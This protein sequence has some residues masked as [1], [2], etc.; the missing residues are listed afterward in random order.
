M[1]PQAIDL[2]A[3]LFFL[4]ALMLVA[5]FRPQL[6]AR[7]KGS[8]RAI[9]GGLVTLTVMFLSNVY[10]KI[11]VFAAVPFL[12]EPLFYQ[13]IF[14]IGVITGLTFLV[15]GV[16]DW[17]RL[18]RSSRK[19]GSAQSDQLEFIRK[20][21]QL[22]GVEG[23]LPVILNQTLQYMVEHF[24]FLHGAVYIYSQKQRKTLLVA[25]VGSGEFAP[26]D[27]ENMVFESGFE[28]RLADKELPFDTTVIKQ[29][30]KSL[31][32]PNLLVPVVVTGKLAAFF[33]LWRQPTLLADDYDDSL[34]KL[35]ADIIARRIELDKLRLGDARRSLQQVWLQN[36]ADA[37]D[38]NADIKDK[39]PR[40]VKLF[41]EKIAADL[42][43]I[44][45]IPD[46]K[47]LQRFTV[48]GDSALLAERGLDLSSDR[49]LDF[50]QGRTRP[51][52][53]SDIQEKTVASVDVMFLNAGMRSMLAVSLSFGGT[54]VGTLVLASRQANRYTVQDADWMEKAAPILGRMAEQVI[55]QERLRK[56]ENRLQH[57][58]N[59]LAGCAVNN[60]LA[61]LFDQACQLLSKELRTT[62]VRISTY[63]NGR[64]FLRSRALATLRQIE[65]ITPADGSMILSLMPHHE[66]VRDTGRL[67]MINPQTGITIDEAEARMLGTGDL[68]SALLVPL[69]IEDEVVGVI[70]IA[71]QRKGERHTYTETDVVFATSVATALSL[72]IQRN[73]RR[74][75]KTGRNRLFDSPQSRAELRSRIKSSLSGIMGSVEMLKSRRS[76]ID[77]D[78]EKYLAIIDRS[79]QKINEYFVD[80]VPV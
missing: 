32:H 26:E 72:A 12:A 77:P 79:A 42:V 49:F 67:V 53:L 60:R 39:I 30:P 38:S 3:T 1:A 48:G 80:E 58:T 54:L 31:P 56:S 10:Q 40:I 55:H 75:T 6:S 65:G 73:V 16:S 27:I 57:L 46:Q 7:H 8:Y 4:C 18:S 11:G 59:F 68:Q 14:W 66:Q 33:C 36:I 37:V 28:R 43:T 5:K 71:E 24:G 9:S 70:S 34:L 21:A 69:K 13:L 51:V 61:T 25:A 35:A 2:A 76:S 52:I 44:T 29:T 41:R 63:E 22:V 19:L 50:L 20:I 64:G 45:I 62:L 17:L 47:S 23:R 15:S 78:L 74:R